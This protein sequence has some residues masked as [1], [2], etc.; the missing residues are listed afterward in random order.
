M[1][2]EK[3]KEEST[4]IEFND[5]KACHKNDENTNTFRLSDVKEEK[6]KEIS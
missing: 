4:D 1:K 5:Q 2:D 3:E 6:K